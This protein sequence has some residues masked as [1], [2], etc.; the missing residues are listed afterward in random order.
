MKDENILDKI[1]SELEKQMVDICNQSINKDNIDYLF[2]IEDIH[3]DIANENYWKEKINMRYVNLN[4]GRY[5]DSYSR[6]RSRDSRGR[7][8]GDYNEYGRSYRGEDY[9]KDMMDQYHGYYMDNEKY[10]ADDATLDSLN[11]ML[12]SGKDFFKHLK[13]NAKSQ[14]EIE[15]IK[16]AAREIAEM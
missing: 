16:E 1:S 14:D 12:H 9:L 5:G 8:M 4:R 7:Y 11:A 15:M 10:G 13:Q 2:K 3:K 6:G